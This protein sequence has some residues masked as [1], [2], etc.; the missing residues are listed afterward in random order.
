MLA[1]AAGMVVAAVLALSPLFDALASNPRP[2]RI[3]LT[4]ALLAA[5]GLAMGMPM[6]AA[7]RVLAARRADLVPWAWGVNGAASV[8]GSIAAL[9]VAL[10]AAFNAAL[11][12]GAGFWSLARAA[13]DSAAPARVAR[14]GPP[15]VRIRWNSLAPRSD[16]K[17]GSSSTWRR[18][19][20]PS[21]SP[22]ASSFSA[23]SR[24]PWTACKRAVCT[25]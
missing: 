19:P 2:A 18:S 7:V 17:S 12:L 3:A 21:A 5:L 14:R 22:C 25:K 8:F 6:P 10:A 13:A 4:V 24:R 11:L 20:K 23:S 15:G 16:S 1:L 9:G